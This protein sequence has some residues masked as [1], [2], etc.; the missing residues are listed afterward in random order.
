MT[1]KFDM[2]KLKN[3]EERR[4]LQANFK[5][6]TTNLETHLA[7]AM[8]SGIHLKSCIQTTAEGTI[9]YKESKNIKNQF[10]AF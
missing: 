7:I 8:N 1:K 4:K 2:E 3:E 10:Y 6:K 9:G 5:E